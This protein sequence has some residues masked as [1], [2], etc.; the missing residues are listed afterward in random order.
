MDASVATANFARWKDTLLAR[1]PKNVAALYVDNATLIPTLAKKV[2][3]D[4]AGVEAYFTFF[5]TFNPS[6]SMVEE[7]VVDI[8]EDSYLHCGVYRFTLTMQG[9]EQDVDAR[10]SMLWKKTGGEWKILHHHSSR[11]PVL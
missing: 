9:T 3:T 8:A 1:K 10:F 6:A 11:I 5:D 7:H 2:I 4:L